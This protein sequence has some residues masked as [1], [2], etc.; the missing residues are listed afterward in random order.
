[1]PGRI[2]N[3]KMDK[4]VKQFYSNK[5]RMAK[6]TVFGNLITFSHQKLNILLKILATSCKLYQ[7]RYH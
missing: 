1:M 6:T 4:D 2:T 7:H 5:K 3:K